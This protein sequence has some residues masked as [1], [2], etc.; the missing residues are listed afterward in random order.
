MATGQRGKELLSGGDRF[1]RRPGLVS[2][3]LAPGFQSIINAVDAGLER[4]SMLAHLPDGTTRLLGGRGPGFEARIDLKDWRALIRLA[5]GGSIGWYQGYEAGEWDSDGLVSLLAVMGDNARALGDTARSSGPFRWAAN[6]AHWLNRN[7]SK[8]SMRNI[9]AH[10][11]LGNDFYGAWLDPS[12]T[13]SSALGLSQ[14]ASEAEFEAAQR[15]KN[16]ALIERFGELGPLIAVGGLGL[17][18]VLITLPALLRKQK[19]PDRK[20]HV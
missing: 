12:M 16:E 5:T 8:G 13:Y 7:S 20:S 11:D 17:L 10:Y 18:L 6:F 15:A 4:G 19:D 14:N 3:W 1:A 9:A 2:R